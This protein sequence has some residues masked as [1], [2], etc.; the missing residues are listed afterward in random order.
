LNEWTVNASFYAFVFI[1][2]AFIIQ[3]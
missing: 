1:W 3:R 2:K